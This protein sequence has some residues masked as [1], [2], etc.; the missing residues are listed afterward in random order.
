MGDTHNYTQGG[1]ERQR[2]NAG[3]ALYLSGG[4][5]ALRLEPSGVLKLD[6]HTSGSRIFW[7]FEQFKLMDLIFIII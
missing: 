1:F 7:G 6:V 2:K 4:C 3:T 5:Y